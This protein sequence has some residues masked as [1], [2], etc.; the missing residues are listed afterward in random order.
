V[1]PGLPINV[2]DQYWQAV[3]LLNAVADSLDGAIS[4]E[5]FRQNRA[6]VIP[7]LAGDVLSRGVLIEKAVKDLLNE[8]SNETT[9]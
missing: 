6:V 2:V 1:I 9:V 3:R 5:G 8:L 4:S 7:Q